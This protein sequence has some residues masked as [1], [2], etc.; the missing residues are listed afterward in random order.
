MLAFTNSDYA[1]Y[2]DDR[3]SASGYV[4]LLSFRAVLSSSKKQ[5]LVTLSTTEA[6]FMAVVMCACQAFWLKK[7]LNELGNV[8]TA[9]LSNYIKIW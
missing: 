3:K 7:I 9:Q 2:M 4:F 8:T 1:G 5:P 6:E